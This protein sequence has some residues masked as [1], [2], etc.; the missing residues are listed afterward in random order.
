MA[1]DVIIL[2]SAESVLQNHPDLSY[3]RDIMS[4]DELIRIGQTPSMTAFLPASNAFKNLSDL[5]KR[6]LEGPW[7][8]AHRDDLRV[9]AWHLAAAPEVL[10]SDRLSDSLEGGWTFIPCAVTRSAHTSFYASPHSARWNPSHS[11]ESG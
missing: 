6:Y 1:L 8:I 2:L 4:A 11:K 10:Y 9:L 5:E 3:L 7:A